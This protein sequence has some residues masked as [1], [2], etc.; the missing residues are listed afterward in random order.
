MTVLE[1]ELT[2]ASINIP[3]PEQLFAFM[4]GVNL[5]FIHEHVRDKV[6]SVKVKKQNFKSPPNYFSYLVLLIQ[7]FNSIFRRGTLSRQFFLTDPF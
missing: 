3:F 2:K 6:I 5:N 7:D 4:F 1:Q